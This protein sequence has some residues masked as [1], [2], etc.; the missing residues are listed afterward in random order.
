MRESRCSNCFRK[1]SDDLIGKYSNLPSLQRHPPPCLRTEDAPW[2]KIQPSSICAV[3]ILF[4]IYKLKVHLVWKHSPL[5]F[6][7]TY[8]LPFLRTEGTHCFETQ[9]SSVSANMFSSIYANWR[10]TV[11]SL[12]GTLAGD[13]WNSNAFIVELPFLP[14]GCLVVSVPKVIIVTPVLW[15]VNVRL[16]QMFSFSF[17]VSH[18]QSGTEYAVNLSDLPIVSP[19]LSSIFEHLHHLKISNIPDPE[20][21]A[22]FYAQ[23]VGY[24]GYPPI[25]IDV[26][27][28]D[29]VLQSE[30]HRVNDVTMLIAHRH[31]WVTMSPI[32]LSDS[33][34]DS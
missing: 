26:V 13:A 21:P 29:D 22:I 1:Y 18:D 31:E 10:F 7:Q 28:F 27:V 11:L 32:E 15:N 5:P 23:K 3:I 9:P 2:W 4:H 8:S 30:K 19:L 34:L 33:H 20:L 12:V 17:K 25:P 16:L 24:T 6:L 14:T